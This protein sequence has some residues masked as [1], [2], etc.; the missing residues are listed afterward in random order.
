M[1][2]QSGTAPAPGMVL[3][4]CQRCG[5]QEMRHPRA[6][7]CPD[8]AAALNREQSAASRRR[9]KAAGTRS[10]SKP[11]PSRAKPKKPASLAEINHAA[12]EA[13]MTYGQYME[14][15]KGGA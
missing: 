3:I 4:T 6:K 13:G 15:L 5:K 11:K 8:C 2:N 9:Q 12:R 10:R 14:H 7:Y 1:S